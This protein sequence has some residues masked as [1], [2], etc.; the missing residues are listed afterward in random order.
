MVD[1]AIETAANVS[2][3]GDAPTNEDPTPARRGFSGKR[4]FVL[5]L[6]LL[7]VAL[8]VGFFL[9]SSW[10]VTRVAKFDAP[11]SNVRAAVMQL[12]RWEAWFGSSP[13]AKG[14]PPVSPQGDFAPHPELTDALV[15]TNGGDDSALRVR[16]TERSENSVNY[17][18]VRNDNSDL[19]STGM[20]LMTSREDGGTDFT[21]TDRGSVGFN[22][23][24]RWVV[25][26]GL[27]ESRLRKML[28]ASMAQLDIV[29]TKPQ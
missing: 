6:I 8:V 19:V 20:M 28:D 4:F 29:A 27:V 24:Q 12:E 9:P 11:A 3:T 13:G 21:W 23:M 22:P 5:F 18:I 1:D 7:A 15:W 25:G 16:L 10:Q 2:P 17:E 26:L 14:E